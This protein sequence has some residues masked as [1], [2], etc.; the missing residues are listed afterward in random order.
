MQNPLVSVVLPFF[1][2]APTLSRAI[3]SMAVQDMEQFE[4]LLVDN[5]ST[6]GSLAIARA[7]V[8]RDHRFRLLREE[9]QGVV[10]ASNRGCAGAR[11]DLLARIDA[12]DRS[13][14]GRLRLQ[15]DYLARNPS[16]GAVAGRVRH[17]GDPLHTEGFQRYVDWSNSLVTCEQIQIRR[18]IE[19]PLVNPTMMWRR[20]AM[21]A[22]GL[23]RDGDFP[24]DYELWL[25][26]LHR[27]VR[28]GKVEDVVLDWYDSPRRLTRTRANYSERAFYEIKSDY[29]AAWLKENNP[30]HPRVW[31]WGASRLSRRRADPLVQR[32]VVIDRFV[33]TKTSRQIPA[34]VVHY[35]DVPPAGTCFLL[36]YVRQYD[37]REKI[38]VFLEKRG[39][40]EG[41]DF[42]L[43]S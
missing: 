8:E 35:R 5:N 6:D 25:R 16:Y 43:V 29:L 41:R 17:V 3:E 21:E 11:A 12:D 18:F 31:I 33:D 38:C 15:M 7:W 36:S 26:W 23:Y 40:R 30:L 27:G 32:G 39:Y 42:L 4:C 28:I 34:G 19:S 37:N 24:E 20:S 9:K 13:H 14:P 2:A 10:F 1:N 22:H